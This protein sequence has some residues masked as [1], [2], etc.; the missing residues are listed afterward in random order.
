MDEYQ[1]LSSYFSA[2]EVQSKL[3]HHSP[4]RRAM[5]RKSKQGSVSFKINERAKNI[6]QSER[7]LF[8]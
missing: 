6:I 8:R 4:D 1:K 7:I 2:Q 3:V 5:Q